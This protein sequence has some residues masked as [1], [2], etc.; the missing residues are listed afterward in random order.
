MKNKPL[1]V[2]IPGT[3]CTRD[4]FLPIMN[5]L[6]YESLLI[7]FDK[8]DSLEKMSN[9]VLRQVAGRHFIPVGFSM[10]GMVAFELIRNANEQIA[11]LILLNS[12][13]H[14]DLSGRKEGREKQLTLAKKAGIRKVIEDIY[15]SVYFAN[16]ASPASALVLQMAED[17]GV[18]V[19]A[20]QL[21]VL[22]ERPDSLHLLASYTRPTLIIGGE[23]D[24]PCPPAHQHIMAEKALN[25][26]LHIIPNCGHFGPLEEPK[27]IARLVNHWISTH[28]G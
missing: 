20:A 21:K 3:L 1:L 9:Q 11:G 10:G 22:A 26:E 15:L 19:F 2:F 25:S 24:L 8:E 18:D 12:N 7:D 14:A 4:M 23:N 13:A 5:N 28:Y 16:T 27:L 17:L 6:A